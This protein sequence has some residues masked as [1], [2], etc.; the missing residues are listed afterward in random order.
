[1]IA[2]RQARRERN[3]QD[4][5]PLLQK[6]PEIQL[7]FPGRDLRRPRRGPGC[8]GVEKRLHRQTLAI[9]VRIFLPVQQKMER[10]IMQIER[11]VLRKRQIRRG[12]T[13]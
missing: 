7:E 3:M 4:V 1:M 9:V 2:A 5:A 11:G 8:H 6:L 12:I 13:A 10:N